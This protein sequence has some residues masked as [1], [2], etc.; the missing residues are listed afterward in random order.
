MMGHDIVVT[1]RQMTSTTMLLASLRHDRAWI[2]LAVALT[3]AIAGI[4]AWSIT[5]V[6]QARSTLLVMLGSE[7]TYR[8]VPGEQANNAGGLNRD[9]IL[10]TEIEILEEDDLHRMV[11]RTIGATTLYPSLSP[12]PGSVSRFS[13]FAK[14]VLD[15]V[16]KQLGLPELEQA[17]PHAMDPVEQALVRLNANLSYLAVKDGNGIELTF[18]HEDPAMAARVLQLLEEV[19]L[20]RRRE[21]YLTQEGR[22][23]RIE[24]DA[25]RKSLKEAD[26][27]LLDYKRLSGGGDY[28]VRRVILQNQQGVFETELRT[29]RD[30]AD[31]NT[32][33][34]VQLDQQMRSLPGTYQTLV[35]PLMLQMQQDRSKALINLETSRTQ[36][37]RD[38]TH[39]GEVAASIKEIATQEH[40][41]EQLTRDREVL[42][43]A[44]K[45]ADKVR[46]EKTI[47]ESIENSGRENVRVLQVP[48]AP[49]LP[50]S[51][52]SLILAGGIILGAVVGAAV[53]LI[54][55]ATRRVYL[56]PEAVERDTN[57]RV[58]LTIPESRALATGTMR[59]IRGPSGRWGAG[60]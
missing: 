49:M 13:A 12:T 32:T 4:A 31:Q 41:V 3:I 8:T 48:R 14:G 28:L 37:A 44:L 21:L 57:L 25:I 18:S 19:Y 2:A 51:S 29:A 42:V 56:L 43:E 24:V 27:K 45:A 15:P 50:K 33:R 26:D 6:Y 17:Q 46:N 23:V 58:I 54:L 30:Q 36:A 9:Q 11:I 53:G 59:L 39:L 40:Q 34:L 22:L 5:P 55:H 16:R 52:R 47:A 60:S 35:N 7:Y 20:V 38:L 1:P 10:R